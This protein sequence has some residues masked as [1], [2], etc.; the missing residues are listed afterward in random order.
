MDI[1]HDVRMKRYTAGRNMAR[2]EAVAVKRRR[3]SLLFMSLGQW[4]GS[5]MVT[6]ALTLLLL[7]WYMDISLWVGAGLMLACL[8]L[9]N[10]GYANRFMQPYPQLAVLISSVQLILAAWG[11]WYYPESYKLHNI[12]SLPEYLSYAG[13]VCVMFAI[14][15][16]L[17]LRGRWAYTNQQEKGPVDTT[18]LI[19][20]KKELHVLF[21]IGVIA[22]LIESVAPSGLKFIITLV[23][24][25]SFVGAFGFLL[26]NFKGWK[27]RIG[28]LVGWEFIS[29]VYGGSFHELVLWSAA[30]ILVLAYARR[31]KPRRI[32]GIMIVGTLFIVIINSIKQEYRDAIW[33]GKG[34]GDE[35]RVMLFTSLV[36]DTLLEPERILSQD[37]MSDLM[38]RMNQGWI[39]DRAMSWTPKMEAYAHGGTLI[40]G[41]TE[42]ILPRALVSSK[43]EIS[44]RQDFE[45]FTGLQ[46]IGGTS[47]SLGYA[48]DM[49]VNFGPLLGPVCIGLYG[50]LLGTGYRWFLK[51]ALKHPLWWAWA[52]YFATIG[53]KAETSTGYIINWLLKAIIVMLA[54]LWFS[55]SLRKLQAPHL[56]GGRK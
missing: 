27:T 53:V 54:V 48:G 18:F 19:R 55:P 49:Y 36:L 44:G 25:L 22:T 31:W 6:M 51:T 1:R 33:Y 38:V 10:I 43:G 45:R 29:A 30:T 16:L 17:P 40:R 34:S 56:K 9:I 7:P 39:V 46:L 12:S 23:S 37:K 20:L 50:L 3:A 13:P 52:A 26:M 28:L 2:G 5:L 47:M 24:R 11:N 35:N 14:G 42:G 32:I 41:F 4:T 8:S 15:L 21:V